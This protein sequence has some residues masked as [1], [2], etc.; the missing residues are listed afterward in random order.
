MYSRRIRVSSKGVSNIQRLSSGIFQGT[1][2]N[3][4]VGRACFLSLHQY[5]PVSLKSLVPI[6][7]SFDKG[8][9]CSLFFHTLPAVPV[10][11]TQ[12]SQSGDRAHYAT[13][14]RHFADTSEECA[15]DYVGRTRGYLVIICVVSWSTVGV[16]IL[17]IDAFSIVLEYRAPVNTDFLCYSETLPLYRLVRPNPWHD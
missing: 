4:R 17:V 8:D 15:Q 3:C 7:P 9:R 13:I 6:G 5:L 16:I 10:G 12:D 11:R 1:H 2:C 14:G